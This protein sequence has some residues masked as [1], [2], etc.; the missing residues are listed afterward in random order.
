MTDGEQ[1]TTLSRIAH[2]TE[3]SEGDYPHTV[4]GVAQGP[5]EF[6]NGLNGPKYWPASEL[7]RAAPTL[8]G[9]PV[10]A[11]HGDER[12]Q[13]GEVTQ[14]AYQDSVGVVYEAGLEDA[15]I[16]EELSL[17]QREVSIETS[18]AGGVDEHEETGAAIL[19][20]WEYVGLATPEQGAS[21]G[22]YTAPGS[23][24]DNP[25]VAALSAGAIRGA[26]TES[27]TDEAVSPETGQAEGMGVDA[28]T[29][30]DSQTTMTDDNNDPDVSALLE[31]V[32]EKDERIE[33]LEAELSEKDNRIAELEDH[34]EEIEE[35]K[36]SYAAALAGEDTMLDEEDFV[37]RFSV[38]E[39]REKVDER[40]DAQLADP[41]PDVQAGSGTDTESEE[42]AELSADKEVLEDRIAALKG[43]GMTEKANELKAELEEANE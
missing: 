43:A 25:A 22:N 19:R 41:E 24:G 36:Q 5:D 16:A 10:Y 42:E 35:V 15:E 20:E 12:E 6:T 8:E 3:T 30:S 17:G 23:V 28:T 38:A 1:A 13:I 37:E 7:E 14:S 26:L 32:D 11:S 27:I 4:H 34:G 33:E 2:L 39:L 21:E 40:E 31:R 29:T 9:T 18:V